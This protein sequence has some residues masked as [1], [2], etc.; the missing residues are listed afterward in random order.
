MRAFLLGLAL[1]SLAQSAQAGL[2]RQGLSEVLVA[3]AANSTVPLDLAFQDLSG[4]RHSLRDAIDHRPSL[5]LFVDFTCRT[6]CGPALG[7]ISEALA[8][9]GLR[10]GQ[11]FGLLV[12]GVDPKDTADDARAMVELVGNAAVITAT[13]VLT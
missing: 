7:I 6:I 3:P 8:G 4:R 9:T 1:L 13:T 2:S 12:V 10:A 11:D 5:L